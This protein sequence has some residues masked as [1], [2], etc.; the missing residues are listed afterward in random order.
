MR[1]KSFLTASAIA[2]AATIGSA[3]AAEQFATLEGVTAE[4]LSTQAMGEIKGQLVLKINLRA[5]GL[6]PAGLPAQFDDPAGLVITNGQPNHGP[7]DVGT[8]A[9]GLTSFSLDP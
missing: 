7:A 5:G 2:L 1:T 3:S 8:L 4:A 6:I 9:P